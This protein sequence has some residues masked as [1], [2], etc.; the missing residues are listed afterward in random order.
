[1]RHIPRI[2]AGFV[3]AQAVGNVDGMVCVVRV[4]SSPIHIKQPDQVGGL[5]NR[6]CRGFTPTNRIACEYVKK[7]VD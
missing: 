4:P 2:A 6:R 1:M 7:G 3:I 5:F